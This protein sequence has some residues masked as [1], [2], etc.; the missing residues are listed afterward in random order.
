MEVCKTCEGEQSIPLNQNN[1]CV[2]CFLR[3]Q[4]DTKNRNKWK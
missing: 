4:M 2:R 1:E 3:K